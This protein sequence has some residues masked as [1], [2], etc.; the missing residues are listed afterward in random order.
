MGILHCQ[1]D[2]PERTK[3]A[4][5]ERESLETMLR[6]RYAERQKLEE[7]FR[8]M[9]AEPLRARLK[10]GNRTIRSWLRQLDD[11]ATITTARQAEFSNQRDNRS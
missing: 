4:K 7:Y 5:K 9:F 1:L 3:H 11:F 6:A 10:Q 2:L 8:Y